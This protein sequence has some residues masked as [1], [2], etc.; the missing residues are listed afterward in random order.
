MTIDFAL[1]SFDLSGGSGITNRKG[2]KVKMND[3]TAN[4]LPIL[5]SDE[6]ILYMQSVAI[7]P[8]INQGQMKYYPNYGIEARLKAYSNQPSALGVSSQY[9]LLE[10]LASMVEELFMDNP[11]I[12]E[13]AKYQQSEIRV[14]PTLEE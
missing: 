12:L 10:Q 2:Y 4:E 5:V 7:F 1:E 9:R 13:F 11:D 3:I 14:K 6:E 8:T